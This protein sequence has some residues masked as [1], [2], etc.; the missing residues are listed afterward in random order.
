[1]HSHPERQPKLDVICSGLPFEMGLAQ[2]AALRDRIRLARAELRLLEAFRNEQPRWMPYPLF[3]AYAERKVA[4][5]V[6]P[7]VIAKYPDAHERLRGIGEGA[8]VSINVIYLLNGLEALM[9]SVEGR[10]RIPALAACSAV[11]VRGSRSADGRPMIARNFDYLAVVQPFYTLRES[12]P[13]GG[14]RSLEFTTAP[15]AGAIDGVNEAGLC[16]TY[17]Y[18]FPLDTADRLSGTISMAISEALARCRTVT[19]A[20]DWIASRPRWGGGLLMLADESGDIASLEL[21]NTRSKLR[22]PADGEDLIY[23]TNC[24][25]HPEMC[26]IEIPANAVFNDRAPTALRGKRVLKSGDC[27]RER[28]AQLLADEPVLG[29][30][31]FQRILSDHGPTG[32]PSD[33][34]LCMHSP[35]W[36]T[37]ASLQWFPQRRSVRV[38]YSS[39]C[40]AHYVELQLS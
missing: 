34:S 38:A 31:Q 36:N 27:R 29:P 4:G 12:R 11:A 28:L 9:A 22:R 15:L 23:H 7:G 37:T 10:V 19:E 8:G 40:Q 20:S 33:D 21:S 35:Y 26:A 5:L 39:T 1:M 6:R 25:A 18:A 30:E 24:F 3:L 17:N 16:I 13:A 14:L 2:G 32:Q